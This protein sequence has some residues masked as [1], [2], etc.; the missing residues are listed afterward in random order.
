[1]KL[2]QFQFNLTKDKVASEP[3]RWRDECRLMVLDRKTGEIEHK[4]FKNIIDYFGKATHLSSMTQR[5]FLPGCTAT[6]KRPAQI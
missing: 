5:F 1:M 3:P 6:R 4:L 2:S